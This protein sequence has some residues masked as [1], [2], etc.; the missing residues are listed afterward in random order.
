MGYTHYWKKEKRIKQG[1][2]EK[3]LNDCKSIIEILD[4]TECK[5]INDKLLANAYG[6]DQPKYKTSIEFNGIGDLSHEEFYLPNR[7]NDLREFNFCKTQRKPYDKV[8]V[9]CLSVLA[10]ID[11]IEVSS[12]GEADDWKEGSNLASEILGRKV[13]NPIK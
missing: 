8:V 13:V 5:L 11:G 7:I 2:Y 1:D 12:D 10:E 6:E 9:A 3:K 4:G